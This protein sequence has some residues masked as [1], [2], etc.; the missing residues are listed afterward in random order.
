M[1]FCGHQDN[2]TGDFLV[3]LYVERYYQGTAKHSRDSLRERLSLTYQ[4]TDCMNQQGQDQEV[5]RGRFAK[6]A[7]FGSYSLQN[8]RSRY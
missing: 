1:S 7:Q 8:L 5:T 2:S 3:H 4:G 6:L